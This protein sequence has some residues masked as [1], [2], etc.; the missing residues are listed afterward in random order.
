[1]TPLLRTVGNSKYDHPVFAGNLMYNDIGRSWDGVFIRV[2]QHAP[3]GKLF[4]KN[5]SHNAR[6]SA[7]A[8][9]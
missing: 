1:M 4:H 9:L 5:A 2:G 8:A 7:G 6:R 3:M